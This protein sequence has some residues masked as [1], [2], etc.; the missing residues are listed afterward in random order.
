MSAA[1]NEIACIRLFKNNCED[2]IQCSSSLLCLPSEHQDWLLL[3]NSSVLTAVRVLA[4]KS[5]VGPEG[6]LGEAVFPMLV[7]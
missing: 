4:L 3:T 2:Y 6:C 5:D 1:K 7:D